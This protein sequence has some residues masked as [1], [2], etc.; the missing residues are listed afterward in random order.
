MAEMK[1]KSAVDRQLD[2]FERP[3][4][5]EQANQ[6]R[7]FVD[8]PQVLAERVYITGD[9][10]VTAPGAMHLR[11]QGSAANGLSLCGRPFGTE[12]RGERGGKFCMACRIE[13]A[14]INAR[15]V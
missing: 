3:F 5:R 9:A 6:A 13:A 2:M 4:M 11:R 15:I 1:K 10:T 12:G 7:R 8:E 14:R